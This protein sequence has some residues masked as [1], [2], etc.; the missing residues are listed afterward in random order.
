MPK[1]ADYCITHKRMN[2]ARTHIDS[3]KAFPDLGETLGEAT[4]R[5]RSQVIA[6]LKAGITYL[7]IYKTADSS[8]W[9]WGEL[10]T[11]EKV[12][13]EEYIKTLPDGS[14]ADNLDKL[15]NY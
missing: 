3:I 5:S 7:T 6:D 1:W 10:V 15:P 12:N 8:K 2:P 11:I 4:T 13:G 9:Q 14:E